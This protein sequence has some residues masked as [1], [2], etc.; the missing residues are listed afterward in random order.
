MNKLKT[1]RLSKLSELNRNAK[2][3]LVVA[4]ASMLVMVTAIIVALQQSPNE[5]NNVKQIDSAQQKSNKD[6]DAA[7]KSIDELNL[8]DDADSI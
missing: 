4:L 1:L 3:L 6:A 7:Q 2:L 5:F 8:E